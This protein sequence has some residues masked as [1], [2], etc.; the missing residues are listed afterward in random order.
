MSESLRAALSE[1]KLPSWA[2]D[3]CSISYGSTVAQLP[4]D[5][6]VATAGDE[7][8][9]H[10]FFTT[11]LTRRVREP[12]LKAKKCLP[13]SNYML[14]QELVEQMD[15]SIRTKNCLGRYL[16]SESEPV[17][18]S[19][20]TFGDLTSI[21][22]MGAKSVIEFLSYMEG[23][24]PIVPASQTEP[25]IK[26]LQQ[27]LDNLVFELRWQPWVASI[28]CGDSRFPEIIRPIGNIHLSRGDTFESL[29]EGLSDFSLNYP[30]PLINAAIGILES[31]ERTVKNIEALPLDEVLKDFVSAQLKRGK[32]ENLKA[33]YARFGLVREERVTLEEAGQMIGVTRERVRQIEKKITDSIVVGFQPTFMPGLNEAISLLNAHIGM[34]VLEYSDLLQAK[35]ITRSHISAEGIIHFSELCNYE[36]VEVEI[37]RL[38]DGTKVL[39][40][41]DFNVQRIRTIFGRLLSRNGIADI[42]IAARHFDIDESE[43]IPIA[44]QFLSAVPGWE[45]LDDESRWWIYT[46]ETGSGRNRLINIA[47]KILSV[48]NPISVDELREGYL[49]AARLRNSS[50]PVYSGDWEIKVPSRNAMLMFFSKIDDYSVND[51][52]IFTSSLLDYREELGDVERTI[53]EVFQNSPS[54]VLRRNDVVK[55]CVKRGINKNSLVLYTSYSPI[56]QHIAQDTFKLV[57]KQIAAE[58]LSAHQDALAKKL[59]RRAVLVSDWKDGKIRICI[60]CPESTATMVLGIPATFRAFLGG[61]SFEAY[62][63]SG[64]RVGTIA[65][66]ENQGN[67]WGMGA[68]CR[69]NGLEENDILSMEFDI[70]AGTVLLYQSVLSEILDDID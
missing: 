67:M 57:G 32:K 42:H 21:P 64:E 35:G 27:K 53:V 59:K 25:D 5:I 50:N 56:I 51:E 49:K 3:I 55:E 8:A 58:A 29:L 68:F 12:Y 62:E 1:Q 16:R 65:S 18:I 10:H 66:K 48:S 36:G 6:Q 15:V 22:H 45:A 26:Q 14:D 19:E 52:M 63:I 11:L 17:T 20:L 37:K 28:V 23:Y 43:F 13:H 70:A 34:N 46:G 2:C 31:V 44:Q 60:R 41:E 30:A 61:K 7:K 54:G 33:L 24:K 69:K 9:L 4:S 47:R 40:R 38:S 39:N